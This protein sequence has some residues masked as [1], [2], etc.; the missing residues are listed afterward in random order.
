MLE[1][2]PVATNLSEIIRYR[3]E[4]KW[5]WTTDEFNQ[6]ANDLVLALLTLHRSDV[7]HNDIRPCNVLFSL[8]SNCYQ[9]GNFG[10]AVRLGLKNT[11]MAKS[12]FRSSV[13][14]AAPE[15]R[16]N[17]DAD[18]QQ[19]DT[20]SLG[21]T[22]LSAFFLC[23]PIN[24]QSVPM[25]CQRFEGYP[26]MTVLM[27]MVMPVEKRANLEVLSKRV[28]EGRNS[29][30]MRDLINSLKY[31]NAPKGLNLINFKKILSDGYQKLGLWNDWKDLH[32]EAS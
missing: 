17:L 28:P 9:L 23:E 22:L 27:E 4:N 5:H 13:N 8:A 18:L 16:S 19:A 21:M 31:K 12:Q 3:R 26:V 11:N 1:I 10:N 29:K 32:C 20:Y 30:R 6:L 25:L 14:Y 2:A 7:C 15:L 24:R